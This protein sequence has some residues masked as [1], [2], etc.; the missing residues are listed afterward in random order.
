MPYDTETNPLLKFRGDDV[1]EVGQSALGV[2]VWRTVR[3]FHE[4]LHG[5]FVV[6]LHHDDVTRPRAAAAVNDEKVTVADP[7]FRHGFAAGADREGRGMR[8][9]QHFVEVNRFFS[10]PLRRRRKTRLHA[11]KGERN[12]GMRR[13]VNRRQAF[14]K[15]GVGGR[16][17]VVRSE[18]HRTETKKFEADATRKTRRALMHAQEYELL[19]RDF[20]PD[21]QKGD[22]PFM[23]MRKRLEQ[24]F[25]NLEISDM[26]IR[27]G[28]GQYVRD[29]LAAGR[30]KF[31]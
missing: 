21:Y 20:R 7:G 27:N 13:G 29:E 14:G 16:H 6:N 11:G 25:V 22:K 15:R 19:F 23:L 3:L 1:L 26:P 10:V 4:A 12:G 9:F 28:F 18:R 8:A 5:E 17:G 24:L 30:L 2:E 31:R